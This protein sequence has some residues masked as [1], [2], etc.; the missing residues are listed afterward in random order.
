MQRPRL[1]LV[2]EI[3][4]LEWTIRPQLEEWAEVA[5]FD[6]PA[7]SGAG[8]TD[9]TAMAARG[10]DELDERGWESCVIVADEFGAAGAARLT[11]LRPE[12]VEGLALGHACLSYDT[13]GER[14]PVNAA[15]LDG[16]AQVARGDYRS[17]ARH[18]TQAT[19]GAYGDAV[20][21]AFVSR[22]PQRIS[23]E[24]FERYRTTRVDIA[25]D[26][27]GLDAP[28]LFAE[29]RDCIMF[30]REGFQD[31]VAAFPAATRVSV[32]DKPSASPEFA[33]ALEAFCRRI[34]GERVGGPG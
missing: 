9:P 32:R 14:P 3:C 24:V 30:T 6:A 28:L 2:P 19:Q 25:A 31:A 20:A 4:E 8:S 10:L 18:M 13:Q 17:F 26:L 11:A 21:E 29:H 7:V 27:R 16:L 33:E 34:A 1:L 22:V 5:G 12:A 23:L 15:V